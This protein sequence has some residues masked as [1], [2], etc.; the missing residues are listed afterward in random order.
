MS[1][2]NQNFHE[3]ALQTALFKGRQDWYFCYLKAEKLTHALAL[4]ASRAEPA[5]RD[6][7]NGSIARAGA[8][9]GAI[10]HLAAGEVDMTFVLGD[11]FGL[12]ADIRLLVARERISP[13][14]GALLTAEYEQLAERL[15]RGSNPSPF[16]SGDDLRVVL[17]EPK[18]LLPGPMPLVRDAVKDIKRTSI[19]KGQPDDS[20]GQSARTSLI[21]E[22]VR[23]KKSLSIKEITSVIKDCSEKTIQRELNILIERGLI[24]REGERRWSVYRAV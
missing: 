17:P 22:L 21:L 12:M 6:D 5:D 23:K 8:L 7:F 15:V 2:S 19:S 9:P 11:T 18:E 10:A 14:H 24:R 1:D 4:L 16:M 20:K 3:F 13:G